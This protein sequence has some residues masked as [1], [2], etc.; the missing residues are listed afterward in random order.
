MVGSASVPV[1]DIIPVLMSNLP[2]KEDKDEY[3][4]VFKALAKLYASG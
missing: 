3:E 4:V 2:L 1:E